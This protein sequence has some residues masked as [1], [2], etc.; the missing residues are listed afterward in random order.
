MHLL[1]EADIIA[2]NEDEPGIEHPAELLKL[3]VH[4]SKNKCFKIQNNYFL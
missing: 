4:Y 2:A 1:E 3:S